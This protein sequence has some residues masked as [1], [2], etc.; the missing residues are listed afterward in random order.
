MRGSDTPDSTEDK[1]IQNTS[2]SA[3]GDLLC[4]WGRETCRQRF[5]DMVELQVSVLSLPN[6]SDVACEW[7]DC[8]YEPATPKRDHI[9]SHIRRHIKE[10]ARM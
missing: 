6:A 4:R 9:T 10:A 1:A 5:W 7:G 3:G 8:T 2:D